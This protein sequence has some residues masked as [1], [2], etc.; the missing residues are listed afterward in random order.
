MFSPIY[1]ESLFTVKTAGYSFV[2]VADSLRIVCSVSVRKSLNST[3]LE[4]DFFRQKRAFQKTTR[5]EVES[6]MITGI[7]KKNKLTEIW[8]DEIG[9]AVT[10]HTYNTD[11]KNAWRRMR[12]NTLSSAS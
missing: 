2:G 12:R 5:N 6:K 9:S 10:V 7:R 1:G 3:G 8:F 4:R 11:L